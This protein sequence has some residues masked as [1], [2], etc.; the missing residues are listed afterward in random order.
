MITRKLVFGAVLVL[1]L[2]TTTIAFAKENSN[3]RQVN[4]TT[5]NTMYSMMERI[6]KDDMISMHNAMGGTAG[7]FK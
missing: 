7:C 3:Q 6:D 1:A 5:A 2:G 4:R